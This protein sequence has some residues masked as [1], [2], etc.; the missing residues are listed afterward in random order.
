L[1]APLGGL[2]AAVRETAVYSAYLAVSQC[3]AAL[4]R[5]TALDV[6]RGKC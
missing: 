1:T 5:R 3:Q 2:D 4:A 6:A